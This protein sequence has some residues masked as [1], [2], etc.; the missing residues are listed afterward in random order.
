M[1]GQQMLSIVVDQPQIF[2][3]LEASCT[4]WPSYTLVSYTFIRYTDDELSGGGVNLISRSAWPDRPTLFEDSRGYT[5][6]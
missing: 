5:L 2:E 3:S 4:S 6:P 1:L